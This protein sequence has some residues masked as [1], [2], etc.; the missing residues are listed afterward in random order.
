MQNPQPAKRRPP[1]P[2]EIIAQ[3]KVDAAR[4][5]QQKAEAARAAQQ[6]KAAPAKVP[7]VKP[8]AAPPAAAIIDNRTPQ[9]RYL[10]EVAPS[11]IVGQL[12]KFSKEGQ[13]ITAD[14]DQVIADDVDFYA[15]CGEVQIGWI[16]FSPD[17]G[18]AADAPHGVALRR[19]RDA[20]A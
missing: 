15:L 6:Q 16:K 11:F 19:L 1:T 13:F 7:A 5:R 2:E 3:Q 14:D 12:I 20:G 10:D 17:E 4:L 18:V 8:A 9:E